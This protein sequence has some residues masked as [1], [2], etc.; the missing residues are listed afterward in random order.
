L[1]HSLR[2]QRPAGTANHRNAAKQERRRS[3]PHAKEAAKQ[4]RAEFDLVETRAT[5][6]RLQGPELTLSSDERRIVDGHFLSL[7]KDSFRASH[8]ARRLHSHGLIPKT[9]RLRS[10]RV[11]PYGKQAMGTSPHLRTQHFHNTYPNA[12]QS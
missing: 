10:W 12:A 7:A 6:T 1:A 3:V 2:L 9:L 11:I 4:S 8:S 5:A